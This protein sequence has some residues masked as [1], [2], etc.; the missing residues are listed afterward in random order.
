MEFQTESRRSGA[1]FPTGPVRFSGPHAGVRT[2]GSCPVPSRHT[3]TDK[4]ML[5][6]PPRDLQINRTGTATGATTSCDVPCT[7]RWAGVGRCRPCSLAAARQ[8]PE[9]VRAALSV[10]ESATCRSQTSGES[11]RGTRCSHAQS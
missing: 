3:V 4:H 11:A 9:R 5:P 10:G 1:H 2:A 7:V 6:S 8:P